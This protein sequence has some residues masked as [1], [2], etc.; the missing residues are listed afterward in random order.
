MIFVIKRVCKIFAQG[1]FIQNFYLL[2]VKHIRNSTD[3]LEILKINQIT[4]EYFKKYIFYNQ[5]NFK[6]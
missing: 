6:Q 5:L 1:T 3:G 2:Q 4:K